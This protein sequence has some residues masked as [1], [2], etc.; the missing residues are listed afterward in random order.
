MALQDLLSSKQIKK[1]VDS[2]TLTERGEINGF[3]SKPKEVR[4]TQVDTSVDLITISNDLIEVANNTSKEAEELYSSIINRTESSPEFQR[5]INLIERYTWNPESLLQ[6]T[7]SK[8]DPTVSYEE[9]KQLELDLYQNYNNPEVIFLSDIRRVIS[10]SGYIKYLS[11]VSWNS[12]K[13]NYKDESLDVADNLIRIH[14]YTEMERL[15][16]K[17]NYLNA[18]KVSN[19]VKI[20]NSFLSGLL[21]SVNLQNPSG[22]EDLS[23]KIT[24]TI[25]TLNV[26]RPYFKIMIINS[27]YKWLD[28]KGILN[29]LWGTYYN[30]TVNSYTRSFMMK[31]ASFINQGVFDLIESL[32]SFSNYDLDGTQEVSQFKAAINTVIFENLSVV[33]QELLDREVKENTTHHTRY[34]KLIEANR[35]A[36]YKKYLDLLD[37]II[38]QLEFLRANLNNVGNFNQFELNKLILS[39]QE[40]LVSESKNKKRSYV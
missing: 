30:I 17:R 25:K 8:P 9:I 14:L 15:N 3:T 5:Y 35:A 29:E 6:D 19:N 38:R 40:K 1:K 12:L 21:N 16:Q 7:D 33:E 23:E 28:Y 22:V 27:S 11:E 36:K 2:D 31:A 37:D 13:S 39:T 24:Q 34:L 32:E 4:D 20:A 18:I 10:E 26:L